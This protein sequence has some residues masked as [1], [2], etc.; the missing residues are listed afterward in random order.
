MHV[1]QQ[2]LVVREWPLKTPGDEMFFGYVAAVGVFP[3]EGGDGGMFAYAD[4]LHG[5]SYTRY[6]L[7]D[8][9]DLLNGLMRYLWSNVEAS[10]ASDGIYA[11]VWVK[12][13]ENGYEVN[14]P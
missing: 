5:D 4:F 3:R 7:P 11:K 14:L 1:I 9:D 12:L 8:D 10:A 2:T 6:R 13:T